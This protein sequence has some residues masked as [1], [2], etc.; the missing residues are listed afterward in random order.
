MNHCTMMKRRQIFL[1]RHLVGHLQ[2]SALSTNAASASSLW[3]IDSWNGLLT[4]KISKDSSDQD[5]LIYQVIVGLEIH[6]QL[7]I[8]SKLFSNAPSA[9]QR[10]SQNTVPNTLLSPFDIAVPG[11]LPS[12][13]KSAV[14]K[15]VLAAAALDC[16]LSSVSRFERKHYSYAD[17]PHSYQITQQRWP[18]ATHGSVTCQSIEKATKNNKASTTNGEIHCR[19][20]RIQLECDTAKTTLTHV[21]PTT[22]QTNTSFVWS[23]IDYTRAG[24]ALMEIVT[25]PD[26]RSSKQAVA[27]V[28]HIRQLLQHVHAC[29]GKMQ[30][31][32]LR[33]DVNVNLQR[34][35]SSGNQDMHNAR[36][37]VKNLNS[38]QQIADAIDYEAIRQAHEWSQRDKQGG[39]VAPSLGETRTWDVLNEC[40]KLIRRKN[41]ADD[42]RFL[43]E[44]DL[45]PIHLNEAA[46]DGLSL[47]EFIKLNLPELPAA[48]IQRIRHNYGISAGQAHVLASDPAAIRFLDEAMT[49]APTLN[50]KAFART[51]S[52]LICNELFALIKD[53]ID[54]NDDCVGDHSKDGASIALSTVSAHQLGE[55]ALMQHKGAI[56]STM[57]KKILSILFRADNFTTSPRQIAAE[58]ELELISDPQ[59]LLTIC[60]QIVAKHPNEVEVYRKGGK[61]V[62]KMQKL[63]TGKA[64]AACRG[65]AHPERLHEAVEQALEEATT[66][67]RQ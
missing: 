50:D 28:S 64:M 38:F 54:E 57:A 62:V 11:Y 1:R 44:P 23:L 17:L 10:R 53:N 37:E 67:T 65:N 2:H 48:A 55:L 27:V 13:S 29:E 52:N 31:G 30:E 47:D 39:Q 33:V 9:S 59:Q 35:E 61:F 12:I 40:T 63:F 19:I 58:H 46:F 6:A 4:R 45:P 18:L 20:E 51:T 42:Y 66:S 36:V 7:D 14:Q 49:H 43:P 25:A 22:H 16:K 8:P 34:V 15:A 41:E 32:H 5:L 24:T 26:L 56:S 21:D 3:K 60:R